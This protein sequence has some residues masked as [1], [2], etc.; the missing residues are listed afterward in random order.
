M[1]WP[2][3]AASPSQPAVPKS[4]DATITN[5][6]GPQHHSSPAAAV[7]APS[8]PPRPPPPQSGSS[9]CV[10]PCL[11]RAVVRLLP[12]PVVLL[13]APGHS[14]GSPQPQGCFCGPTSQAAQVQEQQDSRQHI[15]LSAQPH[16]DGRGAT[17]PRATCSLHVRVR[18]WQSCA[19]SIAGWSAPG[20][21]H[22]DQLAAARLAC[23]SSSVLTNSRHASGRGRS[24]SCFHACHL[25]LR[26][27]SQPH[28]LGSVHGPCTPQRHRQ[29]V[30]SVDLHLW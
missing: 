24:P 11:L 5:T 15:C 21:T 22:K 16:G 14:R 20:S 12:L 23:S 9:G 2:A 29:T 3:P 8:C 30:P 18:S 13:L 19:A 27:T 17:Y 10:Q 6:R 7:H 1:A 4:Q 26:T 25:A 28:G